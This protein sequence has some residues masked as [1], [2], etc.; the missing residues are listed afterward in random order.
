MDCLSIRLTVLGARGSMPVSGPEFAEFGGSTSCYLVEAGQHT[1]ILDA[2]SGMAH[3][4]V[5]FSKPPVILLSHWHLDH[6]VGLGMY[7]RLHRP[8][9]KTCLYAPA[10][11]DKDARR[12]LAGLYAPPYWP[13]ELDDYQSDLRVRAMPD[14]L[15]YGEV[16]IST[17]QGKHPGGCL[18]YK[19]SFA[20][21]SLVYATDFEHDSFSSARLA[22]FCKEADLVLY[23]AQYV[24]A[25]Y[26]THTGFG[27]STAGKGVELMRACGA[28]RLLLV[29]HDPKRT[30]YELRKQEK[31]LDA[32][33]ASFAREGEVI[34]L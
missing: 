16:C 2:G 32:C 12:K 33:N 11:N 13:L 6:L 29:H 15:W 24:E 27:H 18:V 5:S 31:A 21:K 28:K 7:G 14:E 9:E 1:V 30:D 3:A 8:N 25:E 19:L 23:D 34:V 22:S 17:M 10:L 26:D 4:P 20:G